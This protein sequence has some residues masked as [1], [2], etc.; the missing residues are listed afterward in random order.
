MCLAEMM[1]TE[2]MDK[3]VQVS[4]GAHEQMSIIYP[5]RAR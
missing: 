2:K 1:D 4:P 3:T 5:R